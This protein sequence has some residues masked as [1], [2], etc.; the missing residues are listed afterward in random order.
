MDEA[1]RYAQLLERTR[2]HLFDWPEALAYVLVVQNRLAE[3]KGYLSQVPA[4]N[5]NRMVNEAAILSRTGKRDQV[6]GILLRMRELY[7]DAASYQ[8]GQVHAQSGNIDEAFAALNR[9]WE[10]RDSGL[11]R[12]KTDP[13]LDPLRGDPR[14]AQLVR[15]LNFPA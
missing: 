1:I 5:Y 10:I 4:D 12:L 11:L 2:P 9:A 15:K 3:A 13:Y 6:P 14:Y 8:Y 7:G